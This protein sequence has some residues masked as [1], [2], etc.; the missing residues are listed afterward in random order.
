MVAAVSHW[1]ADHAS[2]S[3]EFKRRLGSG[4]SLVLAAHAMV[5]SYAVLSRL[6]APHRL[7]PSAAWTVLRTSFVEHATRV[8]SLD[9]TAYLQMIE[10]C[11]ARGVAGGAMYDAV[12]V[13]C[14]V[15]AGV[16]TI[17]TFNDRHF[18]PLVSLGIQVVVPQSISTPASDA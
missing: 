18:R 8:V 2:A 13:A 1:H 16:E 4:E 17:V 3:Q 11:V 6:P 9:D 5:E 7:T 15:T 12:I 10:N 14:A